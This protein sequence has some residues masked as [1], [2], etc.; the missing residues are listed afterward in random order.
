MSKEIEESLAEVVK[1]TV[2]TATADTESKL[3]ALKQK[4]EADLE[5]LKTD[6]AL[7]LE[8]LTPKTVTKANKVDEDVVKAIDKSAEVLAKIGRGEVKSA[9]VPM[10]FEVFKAITTGSFTPPEDWGQTVLLPG[11]ERPLADKTRFNL[12]DYIPVGT[13][14]A[15]HLKKARRGAKSGNVAW[16]PE[17]GLKP[18]IQYSWE[19]LGIDPVKITGRTQVCD[20][21]LED[22][23]GLRPEIRS[24]LFEELNYG[25]SD[26]L[27]S[28]SGVA[29]EPLGLFTSASQFQNPALEESVD[30]PNYLDAINAVINTQTCLG[31]SPN[32]ALMSCPDYFILDSLKDANGQYLDIPGY[33]RETKTL[34][35]VRILQVPTDVLPQGE[36]AVFDV[37]SIKVWFKGAINF[38]EGY[39]MVRD[40]NDV[41]Q[42][43]D[44]EHNMTSFIIETRL[45]AWVDNVACI[46]KDTFAN[47]LSFIAKP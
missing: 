44:W 42:G 13:T 22:I 20:E 39:S 40:A 15:V 1:S 26:G 46:T 34:N 7:R 2:K 14:T 28:G 37:N 36:F 45:F 18:L 21:A 41:I 35:G 3:E 24:F 27:L 43:G 5:A 17:C 19:I 23:P 4:S 33:N 11:I 8:K 47:V 12:L 9:E 6:F 16:T 31:C 30:D 32:I 10:S 29:P 25:I 38:K